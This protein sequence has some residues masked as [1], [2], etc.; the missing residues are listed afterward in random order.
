MNLSA[1]TV[2]LWHQTALMAVTAVGLLA[3]EPLPGLHTV[4]D[5]FGWVLARLAWLPVFARGAAGV[6]GRV[7]HVRAGA[8]RPA[9]GWCSEG[10]PARTHGGAACL[11]CVV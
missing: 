5:G 3:G 4:P 6:L 8:A 9:P 7:P 2:F 11:G 1:M 10:R